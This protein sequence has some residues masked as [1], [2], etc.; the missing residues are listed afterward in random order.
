MALQFPSVEAL[1]T[2]WQWSKKNL[3]TWFRT[4]GSLKNTVVEHDLG[5]DETL[6]FSIQF[7]FFCVFLSELATLPIFVVSEPKK[8][9]F[10]LILADIVGY[11]L[12][13]TLM[14]VCQKV[15]SLIVFGHGSLRSSVIVTL[16]ASAYLPLAH[17]PDYLVLINTTSV[18]RFL[19]NY[20]NTAHVYEQVFEEQPGR[21]VGFLQQA[22]YSRYSL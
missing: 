16:F 5:T 11:Y 21:G 17:I 7:S 6:V 8:L 10:S 14:A 4:I 12:F 1:G 2:V 9:G 3:D 18:S 15:S 22:L 20:Y 13:F 19:D